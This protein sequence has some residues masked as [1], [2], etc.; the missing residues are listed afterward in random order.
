MWG[1]PCERTDISLH[2][3]NVC[4]FG[5]PHWFDKGKKAVLWGDSI[6]EAYGPMVDVAA[7]KANIPGLIYRGCAPILDG[8]DVMT[9]YVEQG[10]DYREGYNAYCANSQRAILTELQ[11]PD[12]ST[13][14]LTAA[15]QQTY[16]TLSEPDKDAVFLRG[17]R[18]TVG[19][20]EGLGKKII[21]L[22]QP[23]MWAKFNSNLRNPIPAKY[24]LWD[25]RVDLAL[26]SNG[27]WLET[28]TSSTTAHRKSCCGGLRKSIRT[29]SL[30]SLAISSAGKNAA[31]LS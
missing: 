9:K 17:L 6:A 8:A 5:P 29:F 3:K 19:V 7:R 1:W 28:A 22:D 11:Q 14:I 31:L 18:K 27:I 13:V 24:S 2:V 12:I 10:L 21:L 30:L 16:I 26:I 4:L 20:L 23:P 25:C 15:W